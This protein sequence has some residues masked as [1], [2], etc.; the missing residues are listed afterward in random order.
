MVEN[1]IRAFDTRIAVQQK[2]LADAHLKFNFA[3]CE[4]AAYKHA[5]D[6][7]AGDKDS[8]MPYPTAFTGNDKDSAKRTNA[9][10]FNN[11]KTKILYAAALLEGAAADGKTGEEFMKYLADKYAT[12]DLAANAENK[13]RMIK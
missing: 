13:L 6:G 3:S 11:Q 5:A 8:T 7:N 4:L 10:Q 9:F 12:L 1:I 2:E